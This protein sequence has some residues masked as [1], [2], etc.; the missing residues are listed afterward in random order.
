VVVVAAGSGTRVGA[1]TNKVLL[2]LLGEPVLTWSVRTVCSLPYVDRLVVVVREEDSDAVGGL[3]QPLLRPG[4]EAALVRGG[5]TRHASECHGLL[6][7]RDPVA[8]GDV[9]VVAV[10]DAARPLADA[11]LFGAVVRAAHEHG[12]AV[13]VRPRPGLATRERVARV[14]QLVGMQTPQAFRAGPLLDAYAEAEADGFTG[15]D[16]ASC[17]MRYA[18]VQ[19]QAVPA[20]ATNLKVTFPEDLMAAE[21]LLARTP[22]GA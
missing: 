12:G 3:V 20:P 2:P 1:G 19:V 15:T 4:Q 21:R 5:S 8:A 9:D 10:H 11:A 6:A 17:A 16:T 7:L 13:P 14:P 22:P 18:G